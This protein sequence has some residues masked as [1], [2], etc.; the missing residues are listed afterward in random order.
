M[1]ITATLTATVTRRG[2]LT[3]TPAAHRETSRTARPRVIALHRPR[4]ARMAQALVTSWVDWRAAMRR[5]RDERLIAALPR[6][7]LCDVGLAH[8]ARDLPRLPW[9]EIERARW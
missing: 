8:L 3:P 1:S 7:V 5:R 4:W 9:P 2:P 6:H